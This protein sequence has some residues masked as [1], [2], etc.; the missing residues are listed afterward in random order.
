MTT[1]SKHA[2]Q[3]NITVVLIQKKKMSAKRN[4]DSES[5]DVMFLWEC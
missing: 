3:I 1:F 2:T 4:K 5:K